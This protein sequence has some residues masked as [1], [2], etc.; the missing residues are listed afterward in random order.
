MSQYLGRLSASL[1]SRDLNA[2]LARLEGVGPISFQ[3]GCFTTHVKL[4]IGLGITMVAI[5]QATAD[6]IIF[7][8]PFDQIRGDKTGGM[9]RFLAGGLW[10]PV[11]SFLEKKIRKELV[12]RGLAPETVTLGQGVEAGTKVGKVLVHLRPLNAWLMGQ[13]P[14]QGLK[15]S[16]ASLWAEEQAVQILV[17]VFHVAR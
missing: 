3:M 2:V 15:V 9:A 13:P 5:P 10:G 4:P 16:L 11:Q 6:A 8:I 12:S 1:H 17:D 14:V 7:L